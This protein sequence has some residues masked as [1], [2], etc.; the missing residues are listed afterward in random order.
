MKGWS[1]LGKSLLLK[2]E[3][4]GARLSPP[5]S[6]RLLSVLDSEAAH[7]NRSFPLSLLLSMLNVMKDRLLIQNVSNPWIL[8][9]WMRWSLVKVRVLESSSAPYQPCPPDPNL[10]TRGKPLP[11]LFQGGWV[12]LAYL[13]FPW[14]SLH[15]H[16]VHVDQDTAIPPGLHC[17]SSDVMFPL[18]VHKHTRLSLTAP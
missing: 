6:P 2:T 11:F 7:F 12:Q 18:P 15:E 17:C 10:S 5:P 8:P 1:V 4:A 14:I 13:V 3:G 9:I 16:T